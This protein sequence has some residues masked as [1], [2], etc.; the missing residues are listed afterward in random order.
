[1]I[2]ND[3]SASRVNLLQGK[4]LFCDTDLLNLAFNASAK[5]LEL[6]I[7]LSEIPDA[8]FKEALS[9]HFIRYEIENS[10][11]L[12]D[13][14][15]PV[16]M[17]FGDTSSSVNERLIKCLGNMD[18]HRNIDEE[19]LTELS[20]MYINNNFPRKS[21][22][23]YTNRGYFVGCSAEDYYLAAPDPV[24]VP[25]LVEDILQYVNA[26]ALNE[27]E[28]IY[29]S[30]V[31]A[32]G[33]I[34]AQIR[35]VSP[36]ENGNGVLGRVSLLRM[37]RNYL[38]YPMVAMSKFFL[39]NSPGYYSHLS[40]YQKNGE[41]EGWIRYFL[42][43]VSNC[44]EKS[45]SI[46]NETYETHKKIQKMLPVWSSSSNLKKIY[47][48][49]LKHPEFTVNDLVGDLGISYTSANLLVER[50]REVQILELKKPDR[51]R[52]R[53]YCYRKMTELFVSE[54]RK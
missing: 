6:K 52:G 41:S 5:L 24:L 46:V 54:N 33:I 21:A 25:I 22:Q 14:C 34:H 50:L 47:Y 44:C 36:F 26:K 12:E 15:I 2:D 20:S 40:E 39:D 4:S 9:K 31:V 11:A 1:M 29:M 8:E 17:C 19:Y 53:V 38:G 28:D 16:N 18:K 45:I 13:D 48:Y 49:A 23:A 43:G 10:T 37:L 42:E 32:I 27:R 51:K 35:A 3:V 7:K 30:F